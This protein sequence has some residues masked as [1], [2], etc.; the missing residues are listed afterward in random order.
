MTAW[1]GNAYTWDRENRMSVTAGFGVNRSYAYTADGE[2]ILDR[3]GTASA[4][5]IIPARSS[6]RRSLS[7]PGRG[8]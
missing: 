2:R 4:L 6:Q 5:W 7:A 3:S 8:S 1:G